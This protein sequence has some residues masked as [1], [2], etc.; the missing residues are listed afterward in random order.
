VP[1]RFAPIGPQHSTEG[2]VVC[3]S[4]R[5]LSR[6]VLRRR[7]ASP[8]PGEPQSM[9]TMFQRPRPERMHQ[10]IAMHGF[11]PRL[12]IS[13]RTPTTAISGLDSMMVRHRR[14]GHR[15]TALVGFAGNPHPGCN[16]LTWPHARLAFGCWQDSW[17]P[18]GFLREVSG[19]VMLSN[20]PP[21]KLNR[22][23]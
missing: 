8:V 17:I 6:P 3:G 2:R 14:C 20:P 4:A 18:T 19:N 21:L 13:T 7:Q 9:P 12:G 1:R 16:A 5:P 22:T 10:A 15:R 11:C 23:Q